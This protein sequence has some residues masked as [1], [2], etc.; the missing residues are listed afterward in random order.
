MQSSGLAKKILILVLILAVPGFLYY[1]L[2]VGGKNRYHSLS[3]F[4]PKKLSGTF[5]KFHGKRIPD[6]LYHALPPFKLIN[7]DGDTVSQNSF[8][9]KILI[10]SFFYT[11]CGNVCNTVNNNIAKL[12]Q[13]Y[14]RNNMVKFVSISVDPVHDTPEKLKE[15]AKHFDVPQGQWLMLT[16]DTASV[17]SLARNGFLVNAAQVSDNQ[18]DFSNQFILIDADKHIRGYY[19][20]TSGQDVNKLNDE[21]K[22]QIA[23][24]LRKI[25][26]PN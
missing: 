4:G 1:L 10:A 24:E 9:K 25:K 13:T 12:I 7:Q 20:G 18:F 26:A 6:T 23:E 21:I 2:T 3:Y 5:H 15:Y 14:R 8:D 11:G 17:Y 19:T 16:G 22:V